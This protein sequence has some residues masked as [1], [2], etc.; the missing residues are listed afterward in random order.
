MFV[1][2]FFFISLGLSVATLYSDIP[3]IIDISLH[4]HSHCRTLTFQHL[5][6]TW[7]NRSNKCWLRGG[8]QNCGSALPRLESPV[9]PFYL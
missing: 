1:K 6:N 8:I 7:S 9:I 4:D 5:Q 3:P 2:V